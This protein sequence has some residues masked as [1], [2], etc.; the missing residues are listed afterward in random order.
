MNELYYRM[1]EGGYLR[2]PFI[3]PDRNEMYAKGAL[4]EGTNYLIL[5]TKDEK[6]FVAAFTGEDEKFHE[7]YPDV[8]LSTIKNFFFGDCR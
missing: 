4:S 3:V 1:C 5:R 6:K 2:I 8:Y 7:K